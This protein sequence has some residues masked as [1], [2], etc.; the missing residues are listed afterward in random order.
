MAEHGRKESEMKHAHLLGLLILGAP[1]LVHAQARVEFAPVT[2]C[3]QVEQ[4]SSS[5]QP[6]IFA[7][8]DGSHWAEFLNPEAWKHAG[9]P[10]PLGLAWKSDGKI[11]RVAIASR[12]SIGAEAS[13]S[14]YCYRTDGTLA[15]SRLMPQRNVECDA[16]HLRCEVKLRGERFYRRDGE[17]WKASSNGEQVHEAEMLDALDSWEFRPESAT[18]F[19]DLSA[20]EPYLRV[21]DL[22][23]YGLLSPVR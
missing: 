6:K 15:M 14:D 16:G 22:P 1:F 3:A 21:S 7:Q 12:A 18:V 10:M 13:Y 8:I 19:M 2:Y 20:P 4:F 5:H 11:V 23:F 17:S 9:T